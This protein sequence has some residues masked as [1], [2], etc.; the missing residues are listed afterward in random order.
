[1]KYLLYSYLPRPDLSN[2]LLIAGLY[3]WSSAFRG[4]VGAPPLEA[5]GD[6]DIV[7]LNLT[8]SSLGLVGEL[9]DALKGCD[10]KL[11]LNFDYSVD[12]WNTQIHH[13]ALWL[14]E[15]DKADL[16]F[17][18]EPR[19]AYILSTALRRPVPT[20][21]H[22]VDVDTLQ[23]FFV[24]YES[25]SRS[26]GCVIHKYDL[27]TTEPWLI[28]RHVAR[29]YPEAKPT[30]L[31]CT[32]ETS[33]DQDL[34][35][36]L[37]QM[38]PSGVGFYTD[39]YEFLTRRLAKAHVIYSSYRLSVFDRVVSEA[40]ALGVPVIANDT[41]HA[42]KVLYPDTTFGAGDTQ[43]KLEALE[44]MYSTPE[45][46]QIVAKQAFEKVGPEFGYEVSVKKMCSALGLPAP[47]SLS[48]IARQPKEEGTDA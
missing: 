27:G 5:L 9:K 46:Y 24:G 6:Y 16:V 40:A 42:A 12:M 36:Q 17:H 4:E 39:Y 28:C 43:D 37:P 34:R 38:F 41:S 7:H 18:V 29:K 31:V 30:A 15:L 13:P 25:R 32:G 10:T 14:R 44:L 22:P 1:M 2:G 23:S 47:V 35:L 21:P 48:S 33:L 19:G 20:L 26:I 3:H 11:V 8:S 45:A